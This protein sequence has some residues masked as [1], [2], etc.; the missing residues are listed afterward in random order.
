M[1]L[2]NQRVVLCFFGYQEGEGKGEPKSEDSSS[3]ILE[4]QVMMIS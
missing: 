1:K 4:R 2:K 3:K